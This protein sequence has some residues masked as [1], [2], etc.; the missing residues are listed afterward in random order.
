MTNAAHSDFSGRLCIQDALLAKWL[1][2][3]G[4]GK[5]IVSSK[6]RRN[7]NIQTMLCKDFTERRANMFVRC[8]DFGLSKVVFLSAMLNEVVGTY[9]VGDI[10]VLAICN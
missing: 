5:G 1:S 8:W 4:S 6:L 10:V 2:R 3:L 7:A 9:K